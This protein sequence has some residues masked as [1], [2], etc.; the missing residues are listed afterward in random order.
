MLSISNVCLFVGFRLESSKPARIW[1]PS[2][3]AVV[4]ILPTGHAPAAVRAL[5]PS[6]ASARPRDR[7]RS[8]VRRP[9]VSLS[10]AS[11]RASSTGQDGD[12]AGPLLPQPK[13]RWWRQR[14]QTSLQALPLGPVRRRTRSSDSRSRREGLQP[15]GSFPASRQSRNVTPL[16]HSSHGIKLMP[17]RSVR[18]SRSKTAKESL[19]LIALLAAASAL[20][21]S[22]RAPGLLQPRGPEAAAAVSTA[23]AAASSG[24]D[25][26]HTS[27]Q[28]SSP[29]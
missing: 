26:G 4:K 5:V 20:H 10:E 29:D 2:S 18:C 13:Q 27:Q 21:G 23:A 17:A 8:Q 25:A 12:D 28:Q 24:A 15:G 7:S 3:T 11:T 22:S 14:I 19:T 16:S 6:A 1:K 9:G